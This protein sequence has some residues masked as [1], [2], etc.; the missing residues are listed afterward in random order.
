MDTHVFF[1]SLGSP[2]RHGDKGEKGLPGLSGIP[3]LKG[4]PGK[5]RHLKYCSSPGS[6]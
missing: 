1:L 4:E 3:G 6:G 5:K 2:G